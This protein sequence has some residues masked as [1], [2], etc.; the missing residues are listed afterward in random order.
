MKNNL[1]S[2]LNPQQLKAVQ[3]I[4]GPVLIVAGPGSGKT[5]VITKRIAF[6]VD[7]AGRSPGNI[8]AVTFT[9]K[10]AKEMQSRLQEL[11]GPSSHLVTIATFHSFCSS[12]LRR[13][14]G[15]VGIDNNF[16]I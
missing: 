11:M 4:N 16:V 15:H 6:L 10:A 3:T 12:I 5:R 13:Y 9:N 8:A 1:L 14:G 7:S 2:D